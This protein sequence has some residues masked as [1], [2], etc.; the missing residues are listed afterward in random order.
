MLLR[1]GH[2]RHRPFIGLPGV[3]ANSMAGYT[4][5]CFLYESG[6]SDVI[7]RFLT[8]PNEA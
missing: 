1:T 4:H 5:T 3:G 6:I 8:P 7:F 2:C